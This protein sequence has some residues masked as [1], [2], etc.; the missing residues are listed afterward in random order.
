MKKLLWYQKLLFWVGLF[1]VFFS[2]WLFTR[3]YLSDWDF[4]DFSTTG[5]IGDTIGGITAPIVGIVSILLL[6]WT[7]RSQLKFNEDQ[8]KI[9][10]AQRVF[11]DASRILSMQAQI[12]QLDNNIRFGYSTRDRMHEGNGCS[13]LRILQKGTPAEVRI[14][15][16]I[17]IG[18]IEKVHILD[19]SVS[20]LVNVTNESAL[21]DDEKKATMSIALIYIHDILDFYEMAKTH[22]VDYL[23]PLSEVG[24]ELL[25]LPTAQETIKTRTDNYA[26]KLR[27]TKD[28]C[29]KTL[30]E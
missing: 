5:S 21:S 1:G 8:D 18:L 10:K 3:S 22:N 24:N 7:L 29:E 25:D 15:Y 27:A 28:L 23:L 19:V 9:N 11:N 26:Y 6:W 16:D 12:M 2:P 4:F 17:L 14:P 30:S 20:S 13:S